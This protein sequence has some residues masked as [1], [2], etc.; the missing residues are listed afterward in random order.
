M[1]IARCKQANFGMTYGQY[2]INT[3]TTEPYHPQQNPSEG[4]IGTVKGRVT[5]VMD[6]TG[7]PKK[8]W[9]YC[10]FYVTD[11][12][13]H[14]ADKAL[15]WRTPLEK[16]FGITPDISPFLTFK[17][18]EPVY[19]YDND[20]FPNSK[21]KL[22]YWLGV[23]RSCG[24]AFTYHI[25]KPSTD[26]VLARSVLRSASSSLKSAPNLR[27]AR[28]MNNVPSNDTNS[29][30]DESESPLIISQNEQFDMEPTFDIDN[31]DD[32]SSIKSTTMASDDDD[33]TGI[34]GPDID[35]DENLLS[36]NSIVDFLKETD[37]DE[38]SSLFT[39]QG[40]I[41]HRMHNNTAEVLVDWHHGSPTWEPVREMRD[42]NLL[43]TLNYAKKHRL[44]NKH[45]WKWSKNYCTRSM[46]KLQ[47]LARI[48]KNQS[49]ASSKFKFGVR[50]PT[51]VK[52]A[53]K[54]DEENGN[55]LWT[56]AIQKELNELM[57]YNTFRV[58]S[59]GE[60]APRGFHFVPMHLVF[61]VKHDGRHKARYVMNGSVTEPSEGDVFSPVVGME[62]IK[63]LLFI[64]VYNNLQVRMADVTCAYLQADTREKIY[65]IAGM[66]WGPKI[67]GCTLILVKSIYGLRTSGA[68]WY[69]RLAE[70]L[71]MLGFKPCRAGVSIWFR[72][73]GD[74]YDFLA[75]YVDDLF[76]VSTNP[77][78]I[79]STIRKEFH[80]KGEG[81]PEYY[82]GSNIDVIKADYTASGE[83]FTISAKT[84]IE[85]F[86]K[87][88]EGLLGSFKHFTN[89]MCP[90][91]R[92]EL[93]DSPLLVGDEISMYRMII[94][95]LQWAVT[96]CRFDIAFATNTLARYTSLPREGHLKAAHRVVGY[97]KHFQKGRILIDTRAM[98][99]PESAI[100]PSNTTEWFQQYPEA[101]EDIPDDFPDP[102]FKPI[103]M[104][105]YV[106]AD[107]ASCQVTRRSV[108]GIVHFFQ[109]TPI[110]YHVGRQ[111]TVEASTYGSESV[112]ARIATEQIIATR[113]ILRMLGVPV[114]TATILV[115][116]NR[117]VQI[118]G[119]TPS[120]SLTKKHLAIAYHK[121]REAVAATI[122][123]FVWIKS[124]INIADLLTKALNG[125]KH[126]S[127]TSHLLFGRGESFVKGSDKNDPNDSK[128][129]PN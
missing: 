65:T 41:D 127:L 117:S 114:N 88:I 115:G 93:D 94:G 2:C 3:E 112:S 44:G 40:F 119:S 98:S 122:I 6:F 126:R 5:G 109:S 101:K 82:L 14:T 4:R 110:L 79:I 84:F 74:T 120:S 33:D 87:K 97:L 89:P 45:G 111:R 95:S 17:F 56:D 70:V 121:I 129:S 28:D 27:A 42:R 83:S 106:D 68:R 60:R 63:I 22:G 8:L 92:P 12:L 61:D 25:W 108:T 73:N 53:Y 7:A 49:R 20:G 35:S 29:T 71:L 38:S 123:L 11:I 50:V 54:L 48:F 96:L 124:S 62:N 75:I 19:Y 76:V 23:T 59:R 47:Q 15:G 128:D 107:H 91:Y 26:Q 85:G 31:D 113:Y 9:L 46:K 16:A 118:S 72:R 1:I 66:E 57:L 81:A 13:N 24:D 10:S 116:D 52:G 18:F 104:I 78:E 39:F 51:S 99:L 77:K 86:A 67:S 21:E 32:T 30:D 90:K 100:V 102:L 43:Y 80:L 58:L 64:A 125:Q 55:K 105:T 103:E 37:N 69:E 36:Y 34:Y